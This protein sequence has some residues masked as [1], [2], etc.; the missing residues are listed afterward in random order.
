[1][2]EHDGLI[3]SGVSARYDRHAVVH[4]VDLEVRPGEFVALLGANGAGKT[5]LLNSIAGVHRTWTGQVRLQGKDLGGLRGHQVADS[6]ICY[7]PE[8]RGVFP[9]L[10]VNDNLRISIGRSKENLDAFFDRFPQL[11]KCAR[12]PARTLSGGEQ[13]MVAMAPA[14]MGEYQL[15]LV[16][17]LSLGLAPLV[18]E[19]L[20]GVLDVIRERG[21]SV[22][23]VEQF[24]E[25]ALAL[26]DTAY[27]MRKGYMVFN[28]PASS[29]RGKEERLRD[30]YLGTATTDHGSNGLGALSAGRPS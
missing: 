22:L 4:D 20:F 28:G 5:T 9:D 10:T 3:V 2:T 18:V 16:D 8:G 27:V 13:Q 30:L 1:M 17:E 23:M 29:L 21:V 24:A 19:A 6:G 15:L 7:V 14:V 11:R 26:A 12:R 25:R